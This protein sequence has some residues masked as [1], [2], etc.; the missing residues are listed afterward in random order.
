MAERSAEVASDAVIRSPRTAAS[1]LATIAGRSRSTGVHSLSTMSALTRAQGLGGG[2]ALGGEQHPLPLPGAPRPEVS[3][4]TTICA[5]RSGWPALD[6]EAA[7]KGC[8][9]VVL[10]VTR[11]GGQIATRL[12]GPD[13]SAARAQATSEAP[14]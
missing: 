13:G 10:V 6:T 2:T 8:R 11:H 9:K 4:R 3:S 7:D 12:D 14:S 1:S 5:L